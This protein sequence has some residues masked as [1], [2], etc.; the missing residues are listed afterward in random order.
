[1]VRHTYGSP[2]VVRLEELP[3]PVPPN[4][5]VLV[6]VR[7]ASGNPAD[8]HILRGVPVVMRFMGF[9]PL[10]IFRPKRP[11]LG[12][13]VAGTVE[14]IGPDVKELAV[15]DAVF[16]DV[17]DSGWGAFAEYVCVRERSL[18]VKPANVTFEQAAA[19]PLAAVAAVHALREG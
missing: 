7:A 5:E 12:A 16:G 18:V 4:D 15:G 14:S 9:G 1:M 3:K 6:K 11:T 19:V 17:S 13:D 10:G 2:D 8:W